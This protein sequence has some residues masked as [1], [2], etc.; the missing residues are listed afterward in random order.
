MNVIGTERLLV[1]NF[2]PDDWKDLQEY[3]SRNEV[4]NF[5]RLWNSSNEGCR[6]TAEQFSKGDI[7]WAVEMKKTGKMIGHVYFNQIQPQNFKTWMLGY[8]F[9]NDYYGNGY[10]TEA[11]KG[12]LEY[13]FRQLFVLRVVA[14]CSPDNVPSWRLLERLDMRREG[15]SIKCVTFKETIDG[16]PIWWDEYLYAILRD[17]WPTIK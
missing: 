8:I 13:G 12:L 14:K 6:K 4:M 9:N 16:Q 11:C 15:H 3:I 5:E 2:I 10:A 17:E 7:F 1:R